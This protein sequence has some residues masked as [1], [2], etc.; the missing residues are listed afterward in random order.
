MQE[1]ACG[2]QMP[3]REQGPARQQQV[4]VTAGIGDEN[5]DKFLKVIYDFKGK[6]WPHVIKA[7][8][9]QS[10][11]VIN[12]H[13]KILYIIYKHIINNKILDLNQPFDTNQSMNANQ[14]YDDIIKSILTTH[15]N[16]I[17]AF[18]NAIEQYK[19]INYVCFKYYIDQNFKK[20]P[21]TLNN[22]SVNPTPNSNSA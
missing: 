10:S 12:I 3:S 13:T 21:F 9:S 19:N 18:L 20:N 17:N 7:I 2:Q 1:P 11:D 6:L 22:K 5:L 16:F 14:P 4:F 8:D 15:R